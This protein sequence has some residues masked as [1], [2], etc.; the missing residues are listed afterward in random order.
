M[1]TAATTHVLTTLLLLGANHRATPPATAADAAPPTIQHHANDKHDT[2][3]AGEESMTALPH[4]RLAD[5]DTPAQTL[6]ALLDGNLRFARAAPTEQLALNRARGPHS[7]LRAALASGQAPGAAILGCADSRVPVEAV[8]DQSA[9]DLFV[10]REAGTL[11]SPSAA[12]SLDYSIDHLG[13]KLLVLLGHTSCGAVKAAQLELSA[14]RNESPPLA[15]L[16]L[17]IRKGLVAC[18][19]LESPANA[20]AANVRRQVAR[21]LANPVVS[22]R[23]A[24]GELL[25]VGAIYD[26]K[27]GLVELVDT[28]KVEATPS[29]LSC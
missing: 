28:S 16:L 20:V 29:G 4:K 21:A 6:H 18:R 15:S 9:G 1:L 27:S 3:S 10:V 24:S 26:L 8:F 2:T 25:V 13:V 5:Y 12:G 23:V 11:Y 7:E 22:R 19:A 17:E 14:I